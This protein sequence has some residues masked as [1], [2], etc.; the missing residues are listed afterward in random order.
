MAASGINSITGFP[1]RPPSGM[2]VAY[3]DFT[4]PFLMAAAV[5]AALLERDR[6]GEGREMSLSQLSSTVPLVGLEWMRFRGE[7]QG[8]GAAAK[9]GSEPLSPRRLPC[10]GR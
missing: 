2:G 3:P 10:A 8:A 5:L 1:D 4:T 9:P 6:T 7:R